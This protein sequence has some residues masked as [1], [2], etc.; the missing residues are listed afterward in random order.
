[1][2]DHSGRI[3]VE[4]SHSGLPA[5]NRIAVQIKIRVLASTGFWRIGEEVAAL[6]GNIRVCH[7]VV[8]EARAGQTR[9]IAARTSQVFHK[10]READRGGVVPSFRVVSNFRAED[11]AHAR[12]RCRLVGRHSCAHHVWNGNGSD[13]QDDRHYNQQFD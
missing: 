4:A 13:D 9:R 12:N 3:C 7:G 1:M 6:R 10:S 5:L 2:A 11:C 8:E